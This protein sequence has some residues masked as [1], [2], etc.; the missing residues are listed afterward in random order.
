MTLMSTNLYI[1]KLDDI[2]NKYNN[3][4]HSKIKMKPVDGKSCTYVEF[5]K[6]HNIEDPKFEVCD[7]VRMS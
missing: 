7:C 5:T 1:T 3:T 2:I 6:E 4:C